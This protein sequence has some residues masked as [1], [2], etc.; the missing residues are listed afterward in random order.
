MTMS[1]ALITPDR[2]PTIPNCERGLKWNFQPK[3]APQELQLGLSEI[4]RAFPARFDFDSSAISLR[5]EPWQNPGE[6]LRIA[7]ISDDEIE[8]RYS[9]PCEAFRAFGILMGQTESGQAPSPLA[10]NPVFTSIGALVDVSR[11]GVLRIDM[12]EKLIRHLALM[13]F[14]QLMLYTEDTYAIPGEPLFG[15]FRG[16]YSQEELRGIDTY[17]SHFGIEVVPCI[18]T[19]GHLEQVLQWPAYSALKDT[20]GVLMAGN[21]EVEALI[22]RMLIAASAPFRSRRIHVGMDEAHG[23]GAGRY[24]LHNGLRPPFEILAGHL[25]KVSAMCSRLG[26]QPMIWSDMF[27]RL[28]SKNNQYYDRNTVIPPGVDAR[29]PADVDLVYWDYYH[30]DSAFYDD[31]IARHR[32][33]GKEPVFAAGIWTWNRMWA[34]L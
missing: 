16:G 33:L 31:W 32:A 34:A 29:I 6:G 12:V 28:G 15:Y 20:D 11:N 27:F 14:N 7:R 17:A 10:E 13:G 30:T 8:V 5:F 24:R 9:Q 3:R 22:E 23:I 26:L 2:P 4:L 25:E 18:Q 19:L 1:V 21:T